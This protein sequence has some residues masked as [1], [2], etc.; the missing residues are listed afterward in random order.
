MTKPMGPVERVLR[1]AGELMMDES[2]RCRGALAATASGEWVSSTS[3]DAV[4]WCSVGAVCKFGDDGTARDLLNG[5]AQRLGLGAATYLNDNHPELID[6]LFS[7]AIE[8]A[9]VLGL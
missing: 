9:A 7:E 5:V 8:A 1:Q 4:S 3:Y 2:K 6:D